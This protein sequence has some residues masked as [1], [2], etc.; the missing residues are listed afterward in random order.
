MLIPFDVTGLSHSDDFEDLIK[1]CKFNLV[2][3]FIQLISFYTLSKHRNPLFFSG[4]IERD[5]FLCNFIE[6]TLQHRYSLVN[7]VQF[8][9]TLFHKN[10]S[11]GLL[12]SAEHLS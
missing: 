9:R 6:I 2:E 11:E 7:L 12:L 10:T 1:V 5:Q 8:F 3:R 4:N